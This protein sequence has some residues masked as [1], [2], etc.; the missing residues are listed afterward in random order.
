MGSVTKSII[1]YN[2]VS[3]LV[4]TDVTFVRIKKKIKI[5]RPVPGLLKSISVEK[6]V[7]ILRRTKKKNNNF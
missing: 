7:S 1:I 6:F 2:A 5:N 3:I 4:Q